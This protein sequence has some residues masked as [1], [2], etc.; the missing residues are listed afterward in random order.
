LASRLEG[1]TKFFGVT[2][3][4][5]R[6]TLD[7]IK[8]TGAE[9]P[10]HRPLVLARLKGK[11]ISVELIQLCATPIQKSVLDEFAEA[12]RLY[13]SKQWDKARRLFERVNKSLARE[14]EQWDAT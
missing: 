6:A 5:T 13:D 1:A 14:S 12:R 2:G 10:P 11:A 8:A 3:L 7:S 9:V 4:T